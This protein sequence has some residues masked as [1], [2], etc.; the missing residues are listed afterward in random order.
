MNRAQ[1]GGI[2]F[3][4]HAKQIGDNILGNQINNYIKLEPLPEIDLDEALAR[5]QTLPTEVL[6]NTAP[7]QLPAW[8]RFQRLQ[9]A[10]FVGRDQELLQIARTIKQGSTCLITTGIGG[11]GKSS[12][13]SEFAYRYGSYFAGGVFWLSFADLQNIA[14]EIAD[15]G[16]KLRLFHEKED[17]TLEE[18]VERVKNEWQKAIP[19][20]LI[21]DNCDQLTATQCRSF[22]SEYLPTVGGCRVLIT[23]RNSLWPTDTK[24]SRLALDM[25]ERAESIK[26][27]QHYRADLSYSDADQIADV[28]GDLPLA[29]TLAGRYLADVADESYGQPS[30]YLRNL[31]A[32]MLDHASTKTDE[33][34]ERSVQAA[35]ALSYQRLDPEQD[36]LA[37]E[38]LEHASYF[39]PSQPFSKTWLQACIADYDP[40]DEEQGQQR[41]QALN[42]L[43][44]LG[45]L[46]QLDQDQLRIHGLIANYCQ[47]T[48]QESS[49]QERVEAVLVSISHNLANTKIPSLLSPILP[50]LY[51]CYRA[52]EQQDS[53]RNAELALALGRAEHEQNNYQQAEPLYLRTLRINETALGAEHPTTA[54]AFN[55]L[56]QVYQA[57]GRYGEAEPLYLRALRIREQALGAEHPTTALSLNNLAYLYNEQGQYD[58]AEPLYLRALRINETALGAEH[59]DTA[60]TL[61]NLAYLYEAQGR[62][63]EAEPL[64]L[65]TLRINETALGAEH[66]DTATTLNNLAGLYNLQGR[67]DEAEPL[68][69]R[70]LRIYETALGAEHL[71]TATSLNNLA[72]LYNA[73]GR[74]DEAEPLFERS[75][76]ILETAL[77]AEHPT[78]ASSLNNLAGLYEAQGRY[79]EAEPLFERALHI[80]ETVLGAQHPTTAG[81]LG[82]LAELYQAQGQYVEAE[83]LYQRAL[84]INETALGAEHPDTATSLNNLADLYNAQGRYGEAEPLLKRALRIYETALGA[85]HPDTATSLNNLAS[86]Y[87]SQ[88]RYDEAEPLYQRAL[89]IRETVLGAQ[90]PDT[91]T[92]LNNLAYLYKAQGRY[93]EAEPLYLRALR[94][95]ETVLGAQHPDTA[96]TLNNLAYLYEAQGRYGEAEPLYLRALRIREQALGAEHPT[97]ATSLGNLA[98][99]YRSQGRYG[100]AEPLY[101]R[102]LRITETT[103]GAEHPDTQGIRRGLEFT[104]HLANQLAQAQAAVQ[105]ALNNANIDRRAV[106]Q[107]LE[108]AIQ[109]CESQ[110]ANSPYY[111]LA[112]QLR[113]LIA[114]LDLENY[115]PPSEGQRIAGALALAQADVDKA[116]SD[117]SIDREALSKQLEEAAQRAA[118]GEE[119]GSPWYVFAGQLRAL[120][121]Q[122]R[123]A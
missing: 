101:R 111:A 60:T 51:H 86:L 84:R 58:E 8:S 81:S 21:F 77:G 92:T 106:A 71:S 83:P 7:E 85:E 37:I 17:L 69:K 29:L 57:Q 118:E 47:R 30:V 62:Y 10:Y 14:N 120:A 116:L 2:S 94:I 78:T 104:Q 4:D 93:G 109:Q 6:S 122:L 24:L 44:E 112:Q 36:T 42:R 107:M 79:D 19:R 32:K 97:T 123:D 105:Q 66:P 23:S 91:A 80:R 89:H 22:L 53:V 56:A 41:K 12:L 33:Q 72:Y 25:L 90:H 61:N 99:L 28:L 73:Q 117:A 3:N 102:A 70:A 87:K 54:V 98:A 46:E 67:Y 26:L 63:D 11:A 96:T 95:R 18:R 114:Q 108:Q 49:A 103:L 76:R 88:G 52:I 113:G 121:A 68:L 55:N 50:H 9:Q 15:C 5:L 34:G 74:Y 65:R 39:A 20:L 16:S 35:I 48:Q 110:G 43:L 119:E 31:R 100:E 82:N 75:L 115:T 38:L 1:S 64:Y 13:A 40:N 59:P 27:L 45:L